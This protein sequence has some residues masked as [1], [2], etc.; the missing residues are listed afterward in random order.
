MSIAFSMFSYELAYDILT[1]SSPKLPNG[2]PGTEITP[3]SAAA[4]TNSI[5]NF[6]ENIESTFT[7]YGFISHII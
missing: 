2:D 1:C 7:I 4:L 6:R 5:V 3:A